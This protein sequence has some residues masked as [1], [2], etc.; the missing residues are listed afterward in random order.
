MER[1]YFNPLIT[2][3]AIWQIKFASMLKNSRIYILNVTSN[4]DKKIRDSEAI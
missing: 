4:K 3:L 2:T 1:F